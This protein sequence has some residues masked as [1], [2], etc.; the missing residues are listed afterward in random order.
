MAIGT[1]ERSER[2]PLRKMVLV[3]VFVQL[4]VTVASSAFKLRLG[5]EDTDIYHK[6]AGFILAGQ[7][8]YR[9]F[10]VEYPPLAVPLFVLPSLVATGRDAYRFAFAVEMF[11]CNA[12]AVLA[13][14]RWV[15]RRE[16][17]GRVPYR[18]ARY[19]VLYVLLAR[20]VVI[21]YDA[22]ASLAG[23][24]AAAWWFSGRP[25]RGGAMAA[26]GALLKIYPAVIAV[27]AVPGDLMMAGRERRRGMTAFAVVFLAGAVVWLAIGGRAGVRASLG[28]QLGRGFEFGSLYSG[29]QMLAA[30]ILGA[31]IAVIRDHAAWSSVTPWTD[32]WLP[33]VLPVQ[34]A[35]VLAVA[36]VFVRR[37]AVDGMRSAGAA[38]LAFIVTGKV[39]SP[40]YLIWL[41]PF[42]AVLEGRS[43]RRAFW[44]F[45]AG[46]AATLAGPALAG[47]FGRTSLAVILAYNFKNALF[48]W[49]LVA[50][51][52]RRG[53]NDDRVAS[54]SV[55][56]DTAEE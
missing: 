33:F 55:R 31:D 13:V 12:V 22:A 23:F 47:P 34:A 21:R 3:A 6:Y 35:A 54:R 25:R 56:Q 52:L 20:F 15:E 42:I 38:I 29:L 48:L 44:I 36:L 30:K 50:L 27:L 8:P 37:G 41:V 14:A 32:L 17:L 49:L 24:C 26:V 53:G 43:S 45:A 9:D 2:W 16:G 19:T 28:Y 18:L 1:G 10:R 7:V 11:L 46:C 39:F 4:A 40:Q 51:T 5:L